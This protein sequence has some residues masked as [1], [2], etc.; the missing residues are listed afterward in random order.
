MATW[1]PAKRDILDALAAEILHN[2]GKG[3]AI[4]AIDGIDGA[5][6]T[7]FAD[8]LATAF[9]RAGHAV[10][11]ASIADFQ[12][13]RADRYSRGQD[14]A[15]GYYRDT[16]NYSVF[17]R[18]LI[19][20][21][22][23]GGSTGFVTRAFDAVRDIQVEPKWLTGPADAILIVDGIFLNRPELRGIWNY[24]AW[25]EVPQDV[26]EQRLREGDGS[27]AIGERERTGMQL[28]RADAKPT[29]RAMALIDNSDPEH[30]T[31]IFADSC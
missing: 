29:E 2:Y 24:S 14:S 12:R 16:F 22:K 20:P 18:V 5:G 1:A 10:F 21:F 11:R 23:M 26:A 8:D 3:R 28:Y 17:R 9:K 25:L 19:E 13:P 6:T 4:V 31:R 30:P 27:S 7:E 15:E